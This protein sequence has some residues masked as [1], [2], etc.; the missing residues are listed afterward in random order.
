MD[1]LTAINHGKMIQDWL[2]GSLQ[3]N[4]AITIQPNQSH[5]SQQMLQTLLTQAHAA[6]EAIAFGG[7]DRPMEPYLV[8][9]ME[10]SP[11][12]KP[13]A[14]AVANIRSH[15]RLIRVLEKAPGALFRVTHRFVQ[16]HRKQPRVTESKPPS[17]QVVPMN[18]DDADRWHGYINKD[19]YLD[20]T[21]DR[22]FFGCPHR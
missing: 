15:K 11:S 5:Y 14:H 9:V 17:V 20:T 10:T 22:F 13:H 18:T 6:V 12:G 1:T 8:W 2:A 4:V 21:G 16:Q 19:G 3:G 7:N